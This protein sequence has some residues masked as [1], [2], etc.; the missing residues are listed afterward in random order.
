MQYSDFV[1]I[2][3]FHT[4]PV[5]K[6][7]DINID[8]DY[9]TK[10][11]KFSAYFNLEEYLSDIINSYDKNS[12]KVIEQFEKDFN[13][14]AVTLNNKKY[15]SSSEFIKDLMDINVNNN[16]ALIVILCCQSSLGLP[17]EIIKKIYD[18]GDINKL[19][20]HNSKDRITVD[21]VLTKNIQSI[22]IKA[23]FEILTIEPYEK[24]H[25]IDIF[26]SLDTSNSDVELNAH[27]LSEN[28]CVFNWIITPIH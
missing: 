9:I 13:R 28:I 27:K 21:I 25:N 16:S 3:K 14:H 2:Y 1:N 23:S 11:G 18:D 22:D 26:V 6:N 7:L 20:K 17:F 4:T 24:T 15:T 5:Y 10:N 19:L 12:K 8:T